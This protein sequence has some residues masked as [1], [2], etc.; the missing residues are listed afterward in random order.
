MTT[1]TLV[2]RVT[3]LFAYPRLGESMLLYPNSAN[4][5]S[6][7]PGQMLHPKRFLYRLLVLGFLGFLHL[8]DWEILCYFISAAPIKAH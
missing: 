4:Q 1:S 5:S 2:P 8:L 6:L 7:R 3:W